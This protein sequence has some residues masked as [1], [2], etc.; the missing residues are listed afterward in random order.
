[1]VRSTGSN[2]HVPKTP[3]AVR[4]PK[5]KAATSGENVFAG[6]SATGVVIVA[7]TEAETPAVARGMMSDVARIM[8]IAVPVRPP[9]A[10]QAVYP[11]PRPRL[12]RA[13]RPHP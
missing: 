1:M 7:A 13:R 9:Q 3:A 8:R 11:A 12:L 2:G 6:T 10:P 5:A 4:G